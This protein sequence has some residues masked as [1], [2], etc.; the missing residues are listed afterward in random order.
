MERELTQEEI[1]EMCRS[2]WQ[3]PQAKHRLVEA[4]N[5]EFK[6]PY[7]TNDYKED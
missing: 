1:K 2:F 3:T 5:G 4:R 7:P 6:P